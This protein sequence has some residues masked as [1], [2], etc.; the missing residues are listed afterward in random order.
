[1]RFVDDHQVASLRC[2]ALPTKAVK[3]RST[4]GLEGENV[5]SRFRALEGGPPHRNECRRSHDHPVAKAPRDRNGDVCLAH[6]DFVAQ[7]RA[8]ETVDRI[9]QTSEHRR[10]VMMQFDLPETRRRG[11]IAQDQFSYQR[12]HFCGGSDAP[13]PDLR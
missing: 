3:V 8:V 11:C 4:E 6:G 7:Q 2:S 5:G 1:M 9:I 13:V 12:A 10:L